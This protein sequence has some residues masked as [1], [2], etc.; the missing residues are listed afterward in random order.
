MKCL[1]E[2]G[3]LNLQAGRARRYF[4]SSFPPD[5]GLC[6][7]RHCRDQV[8]VECKKRP[9]TKGDPGPPGAPGPATPLPPTGCGKTQGPVVPGEGHRGWASL[10]RSWS[11]SCQ[12]HS[13]STLHTANRLRGR[14][15]LYTLP[16]SGV[17]LPPSP[18]LDSDGVL[19]LFLGARDGKEMDLGEAGCLSGQTRWIW[20]SQKSEVM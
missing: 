9:E 11:P 10:L 6:C 20:A 15:L 14:S 5:C 12:G 4:N 8:R 1:Q 19:T 13:S 2:G 7:H 17:W 16:A 3:T 18:C